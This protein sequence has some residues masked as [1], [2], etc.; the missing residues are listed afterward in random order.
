MT[1]CNMS[2]LYIDPLS[3]YNRIV[4]DTGQRIQCPEC[5]AETGVYPLQGHTYV[6]PHSIPNEPPPWWEEREAVQ[7]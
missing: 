3:L 4:G 6:R 5:S 1:T 2:D 7:S